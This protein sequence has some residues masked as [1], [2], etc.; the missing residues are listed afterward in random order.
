VADHPALITVT[1]EN[2]ITWSYVLLKGGIPLH[3]PHINL[4]LHGFSIAQIEGADE[5]TV[6]WYSDSKFSVH[7]LEFISHTADI[8]SFKRI[9]EAFTHDDSRTLTVDYKDTIRLEFFNIS[10]LPI[11]HS[12]ASNENLAE[13]NS[14]SHKIKAEV[15]DEYPQNRNLLLFML[16]LN[17]KL[18]DIL[19]LMRAKESVLIE[20]TDTNFH[21]NAVGINGREIIFY[22]PRL[23]DKGS[24]AYTYNVIGRGGERF[25]FA[26]VLQIY[27]LKK[28]KDGWFYAA[29]Y[30]DMRE[31]TRDSIVKFVFTKEREMIQRIKN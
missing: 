4:L 29:I 30:E 25:A 28:S 20:D 19:D 9:G 3:S 13:L 17:N 23:I 2:N 21:V 18:D 24:Y 7:R 11:Y 26:S 8:W 15:K 12:K 27:P 6:E 14:V 22:S 5:I 31:D 16:E 1:Y 10:D